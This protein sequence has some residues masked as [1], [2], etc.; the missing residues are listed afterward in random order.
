MAGLVAAQAASGKQL[1]SKVLMDLEMAS[2]QLDGPPLGSGGGPSQGAD[3]DPDQ[4]VKGWPMGSA[5]C[6]SAAKQR[7]DQMDTAPAGD[8]CRDGAL[9]PMQQQQ[10]GNGLQQQRHRDQGIGLRPVEPLIKQAGWRCDEDTVSRYCSLS[11]RVYR[12]GSPCE[13]VTAESRQVGSGSSVSKC[14][15]AMAS[16]SHHQAADLVPALN[17]QTRDGKVSGVV[18]CLALVI[19]QFCSL[20][21]LH[22]QSCHPQIAAA[23][24]YKD[25]TFHMRPKT[26][27]RLLA[28]SPF[29]T[30]HPAVMLPNPSR[31][32]RLGWRHSRHLRRTPCLRVRGV[33]AACKTQQHA[34]VCSM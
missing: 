11:A 34:N 29:Q 7:S 16:D 6:D 23:K 4:G 15:G 13:S 12:N 22:R 20:V 25:V 31:S 26:H 2:W 9:P 19:D 32:G 14:S 10:Q 30:Q 1:S 27:W 28:S 3:A 24:Y 5:A 33:G 17:T 21:F 18:S 8:D